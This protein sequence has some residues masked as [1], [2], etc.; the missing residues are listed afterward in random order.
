[1]IYCY[2]FICS[3][4][5][6]VIFLEGTLHLEGDFKKTKKKLTWLADTEGV[7][8]TTLYDYDFLITKKKIEEDENFEE[9]LNPHTIFEVFFFFFSSKE[10]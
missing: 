10:S 6:K 3:I 1:M 2:L 5:G 9:F 7:V 4:G 8:P